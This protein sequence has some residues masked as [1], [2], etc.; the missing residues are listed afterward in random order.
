[1]PAEIQDRKEAVDLTL[2]LKQVSENSTQYL[3]AEKRLKVLRL[4]LQQ[5]GMNTDFLDDA[6]Y[7]ARLHQQ[8]NGE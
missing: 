5:A 4:R 2:L 1:V 3:Q 6:S 8:L 7:H